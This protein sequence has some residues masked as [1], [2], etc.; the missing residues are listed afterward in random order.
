MFVSILVTYEALSLS[1]VTSCKEYKLN[2][3]KKKYVF[4]IACMLKNIRLERGVLHAEEGFGYL[5][6]THIVLFF[7]TGTRVS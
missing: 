3:F 2:H 5:T 7:V 1:C 6:L 4:D